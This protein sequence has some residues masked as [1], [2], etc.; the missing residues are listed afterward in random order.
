MSAPQLNCC[1]SLNKLFKLS[2]P[3]LLG[4]DDHGMYLMV[5]L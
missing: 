3:F 5:L 1:V 4:G 2:V